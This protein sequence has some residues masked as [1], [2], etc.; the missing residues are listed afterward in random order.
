MFIAKR[1]YGQIRKVFQNHECESAQEVMEQTNIFC[2]KQSKKFKKDFL[3]IQGSLK[4]NLQKQLRNLGMKKI[5]T[6]KLYKNQIL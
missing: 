3:K 2:Q 5:W 6:Y 1:V 4:A